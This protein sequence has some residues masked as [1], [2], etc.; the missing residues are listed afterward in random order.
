MLCKVPWM[1][2]TAPSHTSMPFSMHAI[3]AVRA[4]APTEHVPVGPML[5]VHLARQHPRVGRDRRAGAVAGHGRV[6]AAE[7]AAEPSQVRL[8]EVPAARD[9]ELDVTPEQAVAHAVLRARESRSAG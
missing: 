1:K 7:R 9:R 2:G 3:G 8:D 4:A 6:L 5:A